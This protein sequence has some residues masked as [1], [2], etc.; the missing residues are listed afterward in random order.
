[1]DIQGIDDNYPNMRTILLILT[2]SFAISVMFTFFFVVFGT[3][4]SN[5]TASLCYQ[6]STSLK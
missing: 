5:S 6:S 2:S 4:V 3:A 1:M